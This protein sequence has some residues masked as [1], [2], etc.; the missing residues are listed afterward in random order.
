MPSQDY[1]R[2]A[3][4]PEMHEQV[5]TI[6]K[7]E[8]RS[9]SRAIKRLVAEALDYRRIANRQTADEEMRKLKIMIA[10]AE[11]AANKPASDVVK[12]IRERADATT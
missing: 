8:G 6:A 9:L 12:T 11:S 1:W 5:L 7:A 3:R 10:A 2:I 4:T